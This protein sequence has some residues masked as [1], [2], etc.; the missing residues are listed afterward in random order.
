[1]LF[2]IATLAYRLSAF[3]R[4]YFFV[5][6]YAIL[7]PTRQFGQKRNVFGVEFWPSGPQHHLLLQ[8][9]GWPHNFI[10]TELLAKL[11]CLYVAA[12]FSLRQH[13]LETLCHHLTATWYNNVW[14]ESLF[15]SYYSLLQ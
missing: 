9:L 2:D 3:W 8:R 5:K 13:R 11:V 4:N 1:M 14:Y 15:I 6:N 7:H 10:Q 12:G